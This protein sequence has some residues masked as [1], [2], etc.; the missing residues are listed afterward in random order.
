ME[1]HY[2]PPVRLLT[3][4]HIAKHCPIL[5]DIGISIRLITSFSHPRWNFNKVD[6]TPYIEGLDKCL[7]K[8]LLG[9]WF[10]QP[11]NVYTGDT[12]E[13]I[14]GWNEKSEELYEK[15]TKQTIADEL[16]HSLDA[17]RREKLLNTVENLNFSSP[18]GK[19][20]P[21]WE[22]TGYSLL[23]TFPERRSYICY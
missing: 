2:Q 15:Y 9:Q 23:T 8:G 16:L 21:C 20:G 3:T 10:L 14:L 4:S 19:H 11:K 6:W 13:H 7:R 18:T 22:S 17:A 12:A 5:I 1:S